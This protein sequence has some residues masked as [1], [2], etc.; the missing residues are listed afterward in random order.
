MNFDLKVLDIDD[1]SVADLVHQFFHSQAFLGDKK[2]Q[3]T[4]TYF[5]GEIIC[6]NTKYSNHLNTGQVWYSNGCRMLWILNGG[7]K[8]GHE[9]GLKYFFG[10]FQT[11]WKLFIQKREKR[12]KNKCFKLLLKAG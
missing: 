2:I 11:F 5:E 6:V 12:L 10:H 7:L 4:K 1:V 8:N 9:S 3:F